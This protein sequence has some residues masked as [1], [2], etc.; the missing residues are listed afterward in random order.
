ML[1]KTNILLVI[2]SVHEGDRS[3]IT[4]NK[5]IKRERNKI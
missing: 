4:K 1:F 3:E 5:I 2:V